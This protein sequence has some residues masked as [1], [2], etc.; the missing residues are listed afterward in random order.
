MHII[1]LRSFIAVAAKQ[2]FSEAAANLFLSQSAVSKQ[3]RS[4]EELICVSLFDR[5]AHSVK[6]TQAGEKFFSYAAKIVEQYDEMLESMRDFR[7]PGAD[8]HRT[9]N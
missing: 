1:W 4:I 5:N 3:I 9:H 7:Q 6:L 2:S 8:S